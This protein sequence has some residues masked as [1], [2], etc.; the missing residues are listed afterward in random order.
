M[1]GG[2]NLGWITTS[3][4]SFITAITGDS[5]ML[6]FVSI[7]IAVSIGAMAFGLVRRF[8]RR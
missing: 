3:L 5:Q 8:L 7:L 1:K 2:V 6:T 4:G